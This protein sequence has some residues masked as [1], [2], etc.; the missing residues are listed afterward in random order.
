LLGS[1]LGSSAGDGPVKP[2]N[3]LR[4]LALN[5]GLIALLVSG[6][7]LRLA[8]AYVVFPAS[9]FIGDIKT[10]ARWSLALDRY[11][12]SGFYENVGF[13]D[14]P[15][16]A[17]Y[18]LWP[19]GRIARSLGESF[20]ESLQM[21]SSLVKALPIV[22]DA[23]VAYVIFRLVIGWVWPGRR[24]GTMA[25][26][27]AALYLFNPA[28]I[29]DSAL[30]GQQEAY[31][32]LVLLLGAAALI[33]GNSEGAA[34][35][36]VMAALVKPQFGV[37]LLPLVGV[38]LLKRHLLRPGSG[39]RHPPWAPRRLAGWLHRYQGWV[40]LLTSTIVALAVFYAV[41]LPFGIGP[42]EFVERM[43][44]TA[45]G[46]ADLSVN[47]YN[48]WAFV[49]AGG[50]APFFEAFS[51]SP[52]T[53]PLLGPLSGVLI[54]A[55]FLVIGYVWAIGRAAA[56]DDRWILLLA[57]AALTIFFFVLPTRVHERYLVPV[58]AILPIL[59][60]GQRRWAFALV[61]LAVASVI[62]LHALLA[63]SEDPFG[64][65]FEEPAFVVLSA[66]ISVAIAAWTA[67]QLRAGAA[68]SPDAFDHESRTGMPDSA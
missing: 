9:G 24:A 10:F 30:W 15:P 33:R 36:A 54:G 28:T 37:V 43:T 26:L 16:G 58:F 19:V 67:W 5:P 29:Y 32:G 34:A 56:R 23:V 27:A 11:W 63:H 66:G 31:G 13:V 57:V 46:Y 64:S 41:A 61:L 47:A 25:L 35:V 40:R 18:G 2:P 7:A 65:T 14:Y 20:E 8:L 44:A 50:E 48:L 6:L 3:R 12:P 22:A 60:V 55:V 39:P 49:G 68:T 53:V 21:A 59:A 4:G 38:M 45:G 52:D 51:R 17:L 1:T 62:N 42:L